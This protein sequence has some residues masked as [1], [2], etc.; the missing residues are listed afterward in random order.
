MGYILKYT[1]IL[2]SRSINVS[3]YSTKWGPFTLE[4]TQGDLEPGQSDMLT[5]HCWSDAIGHFQENVTFLIP[6]S[7]PADEHKRQISIV[8]DICVAEINFKNYN[9]IF[10]ESY[11]VESIEDFDCPNKVTIKTTNTPKLSGHFK[12]Y[13]STS[14]YRLMHT[15]FLKLLANAC[16]SIT[17][18]LE[19]PTLPQ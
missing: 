15:Q 1:K 2:F 3:D 18:A 17:Y 8:A 7:L 16:I 13:L 11:V 12:N 5:V 10:A 9:E 4:K 14:I 19:T 6:D